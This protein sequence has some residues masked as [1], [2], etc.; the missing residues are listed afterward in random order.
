MSDTIETT[1]AAAVEG[2]TDLR[3][4]SG[5]WTGHLSS[6]ALSTAT[7]V[8]ALASVD[9][10]GNGQL[11]S[12][13]RKW[14][15]DHVNEDG[16]WGDTPQS[17]SNLPTTLLVWAA[18]GGAGGE[19]WLTERMGSL[20]PK[21]IAAALA[22]IYGADR[23]FAA[24]ILTMC[25]ISGRLGD[26]PEA[27]D[28]VP[29][30]PFE[31]A[32]LP[33]QTFSF[34]GM[35]VV[36]YALPALIAIGQVRHFHR[37]SRNPAVRMLRNISRHRTLKKL[38]AIQPL[39]GGFLEAAPITSFV[40]MSLASA[41]LIDHPVTTGCIGFL[42]ATV[43]PDGSWPIDTNLSTWVTTLSVNAL[44]E[45]EPLGGEDAHTIADWLIDQHHTEPH[46]YTHAAPGGWAW[47]PLSGAVPDADDTAGAMIA[48]HNLAPDDPQVAQA[49]ADGAKWLVDLQNRD[50]GIPTF[51]R[52]W[53]K[54]P[55]DHSCPD[56]TAHALGAWG[57]WRESF[58]GVLA[59]KVQQAS[60][61]A[62]E[63]LAGEQRD[64][65]SW[66]PL[67][68]GNEDAPDQANPTYG[69]ARVLAG[70]SQAGVEI[71]PEILTRGAE[72]LVS[73]QND[74]GGWGGDASV[75]SSIEETALAV[76]ALL[77]VGDITAAIEA[78]AAWLVEHTNGGREFPPSAIGLYFAKLWYYEE[79][80]PRIFTV[81]ALNRFLAKRPAIPEN[82]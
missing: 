76:D 33:H 5:G 28:L 2:L 54:L 51:C 42:K 37:P 48:L 27:W 16:G 43:R 25:A 68:F 61:R 40:A 50:G 24:P 41:G 81:S 8:R 10:Q 47:S 39:G 22:E 32:T 38:R 52:G 15:A 71:P 44:S 49:A 59:A 19:S 31:L 70:L 12:D 78:G 30:L 35:P 77:C 56:L 7:A 3:D 79:L 60:A 63:Y 23:T 75:A 34:L 67:W 11:I 69:T 46:P 80:Y 65:G 36:S 1:L 55:F 14:L 45:G 4:P 18:L 74:D 53:G 9:R 21:R 58:D 72:W 13:G 82:Q 6:S 57:V 20:E 17:K 29:S 26:G 64:D 62:V 73:A 66:R